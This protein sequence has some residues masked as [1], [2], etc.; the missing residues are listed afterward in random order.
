MYTYKVSGDF[1]GKCNL[2]RDHIIFKRTSYFKGFAIHFIFL[3][4]IMLFAEANK[5]NIAAA[6][7]MT[8]ILIISFFGTRRFFR[9]VLKIPFEKFIQ[10][11]LIFQNQTKDNRAL[12]GYLRS[13]AI[14]NQIKGKYVGAGIVSGLANSIND[15]ETVKTKFLQL[16]HIDGSKFL[17]QNPDDSFFSQ[18]RSGMKVNLQDDFKIKMLVA[19]AEDKRI[20]DEIKRKLDSVKD[21]LARTQKEYENGATFEVREKAKLS[22][23]SIRREADELSG[24][25]SFYREQ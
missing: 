13:A 11:N 25:I 3:I 2:I 7:W 1:E 10:A 8:V 15:K 22:L 23:E 17:I 6:S 21:D 19:L 20:E 5:A 24:M 14:S 16:L 4:F 9:K 12:K 18:I